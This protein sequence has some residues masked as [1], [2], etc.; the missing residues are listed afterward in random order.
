[1]NG[2]RTIRRQLSGYMFSLR[3]IMFSGH[4]WSANG[5]INQKNPHLCQP[6]FQLT[7]SKIVSNFCDSKRKT[8]VVNPSRSTGWLDFDFHFA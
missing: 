1:M 7:D 6:L 3:V 4:P 2:D 8:I 5:R